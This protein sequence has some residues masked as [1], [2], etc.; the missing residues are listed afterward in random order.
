MKTSLNYP[1]T[2]TADLQY[3]RSILFEDVTE[4]DRIIGRK[5]AGVVIIYSVNKST[6]AKTEL[7]RVS[8]QGDVTEHTFRT[9][10]IF[11]CNIHKRL[12]LFYFQQ[13][14]LL[15]YRMVQI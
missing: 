10:I 4:I 12:Y 8:M 6:F 5:K 1:F 2:E 15:I 14:K 3:T 13:V 7:C 9:K 11:S